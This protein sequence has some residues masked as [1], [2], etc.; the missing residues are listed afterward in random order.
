MNKL[1]I[2]DSSTGRIRI[3]KFGVEKYGGDFARAGF[4]IRS[5]HTISQFQAAVD[6]S[7]QLKMNTL[8]SQIRGED[9]A[10]DKVLS[11][12]PGWDSH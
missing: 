8:S 3:T 11:G 9:P 4:D 7:F 5:I 12:L 10:L 2:T 6:A 1:F